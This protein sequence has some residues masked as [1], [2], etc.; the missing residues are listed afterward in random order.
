MLN[1][2]H[3]TYTCICLV[4]GPGFVHRLVNVGFGYFY[5]IVSLVLLSSLFFPV[6]C[7]RTLRHFYRY[8]WYASA[9]SVICFEQM[10]FYEG[11]PQDEDIQGDPRLCRS[12]YL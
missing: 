5:I 1:G 2:L 8:L 4:A 6:K 7:S 9:G 12:A 3:Y 10:H 11:L